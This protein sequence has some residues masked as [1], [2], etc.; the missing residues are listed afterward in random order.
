LKRKV[1]QL[2]LDPLAKMIVEGKIKDKDKVKVDV[3]N[4]VLTVN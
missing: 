4:N 2:V 3:K 1:Q